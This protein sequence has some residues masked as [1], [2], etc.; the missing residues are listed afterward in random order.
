MGVR[1]TLGISP[2]QS[3]KDLVNSLED[4]L[5]RKTAQRRI[6]L[7]CDNAQGLVEEQVLKVFESA[8][9][10][11]F[12][13]KFLQISGVQGI[14]KRIVDET[15]RPVYSIPPK[16]EVLPETDFGIYGALVEEMRLNP[17]MDAACRAVFAANAAFVFPS[18][19]PRLN[20]IVLHIMTPS[21]TTVL[22]HPDDPTRELQVGYRSQIWRDGRWRA[23]WVFWDDVEYIRVLEDG[24]AIDGSAHDHGII[25]MVAI[26]RRERINGVY[27]DSTT[28][29]DL[30]AAQLSVSLLMALVLRLHKSQGWRQMYGIGDM[31]NM[32]VQQIMA[33]EGMPIFPDG[34]QVGTLDLATDPGH[35]LK[36]VDMIVR[37]VAANYGIS[38]ERLN[39]AKSGTGAGNAEAMDMG[40]LERR[41]DAIKIFKQAEHDLFHVLKRVSREHPT[42]RLSEDSTLRIDWAE[43][44]TRVDRVT[45]LEI[46]AE[47]ERRG[48]RSVLDDIMEDQPEIESEAEARAEY[49]KN[50]GD[51]AWRIQQ[52]RAL[53]ISDEDLAGAGLGQ[54]AE[55]NGRLGPM[56]RD[57]DVSPEEARVRMR[58]ASNVR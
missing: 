42:L 3:A 19:S 27:W 58:R 46:R 51:R 8:I 1:D 48:L 21:V 4:Q 47:E 20:E 50:L 23:I 45:Q 53:N 12:I 16:R 18:F 15:A 22:P 36:T 14:F 5:R 43:V 34:T 52:E 44:E 40:L 35:Y 17:K 10:R 32:P 26:H 38:A 33:E 41:A 39:Q 55:D 31:A 54:A 30:E 11:E 49:L 28:G 13:K 24:T 37:Q 6:D 9:V 57:M 7:Y 25:P 2:V 29:N 56:V